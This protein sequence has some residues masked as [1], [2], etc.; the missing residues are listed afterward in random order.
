MSNRE[1]LLADGL[2]ATR[3]MNLYMKDGNAW[4]RH[5]S[6]DLLNAIE[7]FCNEIEAKTEAAGITDEEVAAY[8]DAHHSECN[9]YS[10]N[11]ELSGQDVP[12]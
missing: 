12:R 6:M 4:I 8:L 11:S 10:S 7:R 9:R 3:L 1:N 5:T 2:A